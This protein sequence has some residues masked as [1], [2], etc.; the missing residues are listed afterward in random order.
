TAAAYGLKLFSKKT[1]TTTNAY[2]L[3]P[4]NDKMDDLK[5]DETKIS[6]AISR[7]KSMVTQ[8]TSVRLWAIHHDGFAKVIKG[9]NRTHYLTL[10]RYRAD[11]LLYLDP[12]PGGSAFYYDGGMYP[13]VYLFFVGEL[14]F[15]SGNLSAGFYTPATQLGLHKY[16]VIGGP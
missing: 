8:G 7:I 15:N 11:R 3:P 10:V 12:W 1:S 6:N 16:R 9:D 4:K 5:F 13:T 14:L 2:Y